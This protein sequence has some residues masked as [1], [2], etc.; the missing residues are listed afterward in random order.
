MAVRTS[1]ILTVSVPDRVRQLFESHRLAYTVVPSST[2]D[3][4]LSLIETENVQLCV[5]NDELGELEGFIRSVRNTPWGADLPLLVI[6]STKTHEELFKLG[7]DAFFSTGD[8]DEQFLEKIELLLGL[9]DSNR[10]N[11]FSN[12]ADADNPFHHAL[13]YAAHMVDGMARKTSPVA[14]KVLSS[15]DSLQ[16]LVVRVEA[17]LRDQ[18]VG[19]A[20]DEI[21]E[22]LEA[23]EPQAYIDHQLS[24]G[25]RMESEGRDSSY[26]VIL[27]AAAEGEFST[28]S[29]TP[30]V[31]ITS[32][33]GDKQLE[34]ML[35]VNSGLEDGNQA[36]SRPFSRGHME[37][38]G[39]TLSQPFGADTPFPDSDSEPPTI[40]ATDSSERP[41]HDWSRTYA[42][43]AD[44]VTSKRFVSPDAVVSDGIGLSSGLSSSELLSK[45][46]TDVQEGSLESVPL[47]RIF[48]SVM[49]NSLSGRLLVQSRD[50]ERQV[51]F[52]KGIA[53]VV[54]SNAKED[55]LVELL[56]REG[57]ISERQYEHASMTISTSGRRAGVVMVEKGII[58][59]RELFP[60]V[61]Y[62][63]ESI[64]FDMFGWTEG[65]WKFV[66]EPYQLK[67]RILLDTKMTDIVLD[68]FRSY[69][70]QAQI[71]HLVP[72]E[73]L[74]NIP[75]GTK[76]FINSAYLSAKEQELLEWCNGNRSVRWL[77]TRFSVAMT[78]LQ[79]FMAGFVVLGWLDVGGS[80]MS[81]S[82]SVLMVPDADDSIEASADD[83]LDV[84]H[85]TSRINE[86]YQ[87]VE[88]GTYFDIAEVSP[89]AST[90]EIRKSLQRL[91]SLYAP[92]RYVGLQITDLQEKLSVIG[93]VLDEAGDVLFDESLREQYRQAIL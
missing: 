19:M 81:A 92:K 71:A 61:R 55:R 17:E 47:W 75:E 39:D 46:E 6:T 18:Q 79:A 48:V 70:P 41:V 26:D 3:E 27:Q 32:A 52:D 20:I 72:P 12:R 93:S 29:S 24:V 63:Y 7:A 31:I 82:A 21:P 51:F 67:E 59:A 40:E 42:P 14:L 13:E 64:L 58:A 50:I 49:K 36:L 15:T 76:R 62:H 66:M 34:Q 5:L 77:A 53:T 57:R 65:T 60:I 54:Y 74:V 73:A 25:E 37:E 16:S 22:G 4:A 56:F 68:A 1:K 45:T 8:S 86:K 33:A 28:V 10:T 44:E 88:E 89:D 91:K 11:D 80:S 30:P 87:Q 38:K 69:V 35:P 9:S 78:E 23:V 85:E 90:Y 84:R 2:E 43:A 83:A